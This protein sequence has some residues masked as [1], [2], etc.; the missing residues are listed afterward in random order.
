MSIKKI[1]LSIIFGIILIASAVFASASYDYT[2]NW[3]YNGNSVNG[4]RAINFV[5]NDNG[6]YTL[7]TRLSDGASSSNS[8]VVSYPVP[9]MSSYGYATYWLASG[10]RVMQLNFKPTASGSYTRSV[11][12][13]KYSNCAANVNSISASASINEGQLLNITA[14]IQSALQQSGNLPYGEPNDADI[15]RDYFS[16][17]TNVVLNIRDATNNI[18][19]TETKQVY[20]REDTSMD[21]SFSWTPSYSQAGNYNVEIATSVPDAKCSS[22]SA[23]TSSAS[24][25][26]N[27]VNAAPVLDAI[28]SKAVKTGNLLGFA[29]NASDSDGGALTYSASGLPAGASF[30]AATKLFS[31]T[32]SSSQVG[33]YHVNFSVSDGLLSDSEDVLISVSDGTPNDAPEFI[34]LDDEFF[35]R[36]NMHAWWGI[37]AIADDSNG[38]DSMWIN[39]DGVTYSNVT[40]A[41]MSDAEDKMENLTGYGLPFLLCVRNFS[42]NFYGAGHLCSLFVPDLNKGSYSYTWYANDT[43]GKMNSANGEVVVYNDIPQYSNIK[44]TPADPAIYVVNQTY[45]FNITWTDRDGG[46]AWIDFNGKTYYDLYWADSISENEI[47]EIIANEG[48]IVLIGDD[49]SI[50]SFR[51]KNLN[52]GTYLYNWHARDKLSNENSTGNLTYIVKAS[53]Q[54]GGE[55]GGEDDDDKEIHEITNEELSAGHTFYLDVGERA[56]FSFCG[57]PYYLKL[58]DIDNDDDKASF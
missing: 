1:S 48:G 51:T 38:I 53:Q 35:G 28:G 54:T 11:N 43:L 3:F 24:V 17:Q 41:N 25:A 46:R 45:E 21:V 22:A 40:Y 34:V 9:S 49:D 23:R 31:W 32:P 57:A 37:F 47:N 58:T 27:N 15:V 13:E 4:V 14:N 29:V 6:C 42:E 8:I 20:I 36:D 55:D 50:Y 52:N 7:G 10:F 39:F 12:F 5:C 26:V 18:V 16:A 30:N 33:N 56:K 19:Y 44:E 2:T